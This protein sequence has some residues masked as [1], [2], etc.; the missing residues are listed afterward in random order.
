MQIPAVEK[1]IG[2][3]GKRD[4][5]IGYFTKIIAAKAVSDK[6]NGQDGGVVTALLSYAL[7]N[8]SVDRVVTVKQ[9]ERAWEP[10]TAVVGSTAELL[11][12]AGTIYSMA[13]TMQAL[14]E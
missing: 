13:I 14:K 11:K 10:E 7:D 6:I 1:A 9:G 8:Q 5:E 12:T 2:F 4:E 3:S